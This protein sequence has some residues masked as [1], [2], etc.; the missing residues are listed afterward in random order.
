MVPLKRDGGK[1][2]VIIFVSNPG[3]AD[4][5]T[6]M[7]PKRGF[8]CDGILSSC[9]AY[10]VF[11]WE[12]RNIL[13]LYWV[14]E[15]QCIA[16]VRA[17]AALWRNDLMKFYDHE[18]QYIVYVRMIFIIMPG[19]RRFWVG[20][21]QYIA[22]VRMIFMIMS[23]L[24]RFGWERRNILRLYGLIKNFTDAPIPTPV[25][26]RRDRCS[27]PECSDPYTSALA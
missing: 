20:E 5:G 26:W 8:G 3:F 10:G 25:P 6:K 18:R 27:D 2:F 22:S 4:V 23:R 1:C 7:P 13:R 21:T 24:R 12:R 19:L 14:R 16:S 15:R 17:P 11:G 9:H